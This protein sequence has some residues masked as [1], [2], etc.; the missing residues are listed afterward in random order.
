MSEEEY[1]AA[2]YGPDF[3]DYDPD[4]PFGELECDRDAE[5]DARHEIAVN[6][7][8]KL[9]NGSVAH[10]NQR[11]SGFAVG[12]IDN[13]EAAVHVWANGKTEAGSGYDLVEQLKDGN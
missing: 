3:N 11:G 8:W 6:E 1:L 9:R 7:F 12:V 13:S 5:V 2:H 10:I 4:D